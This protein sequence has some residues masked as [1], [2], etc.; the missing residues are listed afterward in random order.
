VAFAAAIGALLMF[1]LDRW[2]IVGLTQRTAKSLSLLPDSL[3][4]ATD[5][6]LGWEWSAR[7]GAALSSWFEYRPAPLP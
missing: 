4:L 1:P 6:P 7:F 5:G 2:A 3:R